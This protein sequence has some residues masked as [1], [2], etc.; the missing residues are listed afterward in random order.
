MDNEHSSSDLADAAT[1]ASPQGLPPDG[2]GW[3]AL[4]G[5]VITKGQAFVTEPQFSDLYC[6]GFGC[7]KESGQP[8]V[9]TVAAGLAEALRPLPCYRCGKVPTVDGNG[10]YPVVS[11]DN[12]YDGASDSGSRNEVGSGLTRSEAV[13]NWNERME[14]EEPFVPVG[15]VR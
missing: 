1:D 3:C 10:G 9:A 11:C 2:I 7:A 13:R 6:V 15:D 8:S 14:M 12:C 5:D 4:C